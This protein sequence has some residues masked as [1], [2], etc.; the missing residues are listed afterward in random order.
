ME[1]G[2]IQRNF[3]RLLRAGA[4][5]EI[6]PVEPMSTYKWERL[7]QMAL[8]QNVLKL[9][10][11]GIEKQKSVAS[12]NLP[13]AM[14]QR[15]VN[16]AP[17]SID[18]SLQLSNPFLRNRFKRIKQQESRAAAA[19]LHTLRLLEHI[20]QNV[21]VMLNRGISLYELIELGHFIRTNA[22]KIDADKLDK[23]LHGLHLYRMAQLQG[24]MLVELF[25]FDADEIPFLHEFQENTISLVM[26]TM[27][28]TEADT[29]EEWHFKQT[30]V[31]FV[32]NNSKLLRRNLKRSIRYLPFAPLETSSN[33]VVNFAKSLSEIE[34]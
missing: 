15:F 2:V 10:L 18:N 30:R 14:I 22:A 26:R 7:L 25:E 28:H 31:G 1:I 13:Q 3:F 23:W 19:S 32:Q 9:T 29:A 11:S 8:A 20:V 24:S 27:N 5:N 17:S 21:C 16:I 12:L 4:M 33:F 6:D 34:E